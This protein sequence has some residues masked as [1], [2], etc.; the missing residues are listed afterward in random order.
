M[1]SVIRRAGVPNMVVRWKHVFVFNNDLYVTDV[2]V[3]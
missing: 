2:K 3:L 1:V